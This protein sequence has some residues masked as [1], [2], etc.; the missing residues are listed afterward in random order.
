MTIRRN[1]PVPKPRHVNPELRQGQTYRIIGAGTTS[2]QDHIGRYFTAAMCAGC[3][4]LVYMIDT[5]EHGGYDA[6]NVIN[7]HKLEF[8][9]VNL[10]EV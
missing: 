1:Q 10:Q 2:Y 6:V 9:T 4:Y 3:T 8:V 7:T 5:E